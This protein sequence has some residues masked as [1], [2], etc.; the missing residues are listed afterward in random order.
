M[1]R[2]KVGLRVCGVLL[3]LVGVMCLP[4]GYGVSPK[5]DLSVFANL[6]DTGAFLRA[7]FVLIPSGLIVLV[8]SCFVPGDV[9]EF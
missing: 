5:R 2:L 1:S 8:V 3:A 9:D 4:V 7:A 6:A